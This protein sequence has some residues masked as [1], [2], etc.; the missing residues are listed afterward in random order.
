MSLTA[1]LSNECLI[2]W[3]KGKL[4]EQGE[5]GTI[6]IA[7]NYGNGQLMT[8]NKISVTRTDQEAIT[9]LHND[10]E[11]LEKLKFKCN[12]AQYIGIED[13]S[14]IGHMN[15]FIEFVPGGS[16]ASLLT[17]F[18]PL[19]HELVSNYTR[20]VIEGLMYLHREGVVH[21]DIKGAN[22]IVKACGSLILSGFGASQLSK[23][24]KVP[25]KN[26]WMPPEV[27]VKGITAPVTWRQDIWSLGC[28]V[29]EMLT[30]KAPFKWLSGTD[31]DILM[32]IA[33]T[34][35]RSRM[36]PIG[37]TPETRSFLRVCLQ[38]NPSRRPEA[39][40]LFYHDF[41]NMIYVSGEE[42]NSD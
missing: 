5:F 22:V 24:K 35:I 17:E 6:H 8:V 7:I 39:K 11:A 23:L 37:L 25:C 14:E 21:R 41:I 15:I 36:P 31:E 27:I 4:L 2:K 34:E 30:A 42:D 29:I 1:E 3:K 20:Q 32:N 40:E 38:K 13:N 19:S 9:Q 28:L 16:I 10:I 12:I 26:L 18:G 33:N